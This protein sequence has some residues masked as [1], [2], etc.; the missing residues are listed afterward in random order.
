VIT[1]GAATVCEAFQAATEAFPDRVAWRTK[2]DAVSY[3]WGEAGERV[4]RLAAGFHALGVRRG[5]T[6]A[7]MLVN[8]PEFHVAD[9]AAMH[10]GATC[11]SIYN[12]LA[13]DQIA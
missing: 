13:P 12:T 6:F 3:T 8:R 9:A 5:D 4:R 2:D 1:T 11:F 7:L 10:L